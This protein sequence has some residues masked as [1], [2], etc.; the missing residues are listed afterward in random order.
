MNVFQHVFIITVELIF[1][2][3]VYDKIYL[4]LFNQEICHEF[5][6]TPESCIYSSCI[7]ETVVDSAESE[8]VVRVYVCLC[9]CVCVLTPGFLKAYDI[10]PTHGRH[11]YHLPHTLMQSCDL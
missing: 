8:P 6:M 11:L 1:F 9:V 7:F 3:E 10:D 5:H 4:K 2:N